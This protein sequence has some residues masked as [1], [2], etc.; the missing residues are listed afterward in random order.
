MEG[1]ILVT[2]CAGFIGMHLASALLRRGCRV[3]GLDNLSDFYSVQLKKDRLKQLESPDFVFYPASLIDQKS[4]QK[5]F[6]KE[7][8]TQVC[9]LAA[10]PGVRYSVDFPFVSMKTNIEGF[11]NLLETVKDKKLKNFVY[12]SSSSVYGGNTKTPFSVEDRVDSPIS[13]YAATKKTNE[14]FAHTYNQLYGLKTTGLRFFTVY[15]PWGRPD[16][17]IYKFATK[18]MK[19]QPIDV[20]NYGDMWRDFTYVDDIVSGIVAALDTVFDYEIFNLGNSTPVKIGQVI[21]I[22]EACLGREA[23]KNFL[24]L[25]Q[26]DMLK[27][28]A[29][30]EKSSRLLGFSP[31]TSIEQGI[32]N[33]ANWFLDYHAKDF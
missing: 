32:K 6:E 27:T 5:I 18:I 3:A 20:Y 7:N 13:L 12:A 16:M 33:F 1:S 9:H 28:M 15:G 26:G 14:L 10:Q 31:E 17:A 25:Q 22:L 11:L 19:G 24:P 30:I 21:S 4:I 23:E 2:G 8:I 29:D